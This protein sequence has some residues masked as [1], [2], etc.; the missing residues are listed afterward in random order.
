MT[1][2]YHD[3][4]LYF[5]RKVLHGF[6]LIYSDDEIELSIIDHREGPLQPV[7][8]TE[9]VDNESS[10]QDEAVYFSSPYEN[11]LLND[12]APRDFC[13]WHH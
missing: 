8:S 4:K 2:K 5:D 12:V 3:I 13:Y 1:L 11:S 9:P 6:Y 7:T 10:P